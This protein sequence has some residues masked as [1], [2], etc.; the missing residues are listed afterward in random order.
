[1]YAFIWLTKDRALQKAS[2]E[3]TYLKGIEEKSDL[4]DKAA[5]KFSSKVTA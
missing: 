2:P 1:L 5:A 4:F 3:H